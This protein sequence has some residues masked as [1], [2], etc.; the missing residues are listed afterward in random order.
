MVAAGAG[1]EDWAWCGKKG[2]AAGF[3]L[4]RK[5][6]AA[7]AGS[8]R[9]RVA[10]CGGS[11]AAGRLPG[12]RW[13]GSCV[14]AIAFAGGS[15]AGGKRGAARRAAWNLRLSCSATRLLS[16]THDEPAGGPGKRMK[17]TRGGIY[18]CVY[19]LLDKGDWKKKNVYFI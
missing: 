13:L 16:G 2:G 14:F 6:L 15:R 9:W 8:T 1:A 11:E 12:L 18:V 3:R 7:M 17:G 10:A 19:A 5:A 4:E